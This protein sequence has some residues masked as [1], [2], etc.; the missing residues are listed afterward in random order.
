M[1]LSDFKTQLSLTATALTED[2]K[3]IRTGR[4]NPIIIEQLVVD[5]YGGSTKLKLMEMATI[6]TEGP[7]ALV[8]IPFDPSIVPDIEKAILK[9][10]LGLSPQVQGTRLIIRVPPLSEEQREKYVKLVNQ[11][12]EEK[13]NIVRNHRD[14]VRKKIKTQFD[15]KTVT[16][17]EKYRLEKEI[18]TITQKANSQL[19][20][21]KETKEK[22]IREI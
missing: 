14:D 1:D 19:L 8:I 10:P 11:K 18:D 15:E 9:S 12:I 13:R 3:T 2:L 6:T 17:D 5:A 4:A 22:E 20:E 7:A 16:E 21:I